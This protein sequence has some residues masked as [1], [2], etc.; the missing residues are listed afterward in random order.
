MVFRFCG[1]AINLTL[2]I[3]TTFSSEGQIIG[4]D[5]PPL[6]TPTSSLDLT[7]LLA[8]LY[9]S[10]GNAIFPSKICSEMPESADLRMCWAEVLPLF[11]F[12]FQSLSR[13]C[14]QIFLARG[15]LVSKALRHH[16]SFVMKYSMTVGTTSLVIKALQEKILVKPL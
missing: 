8:L 6:P 9:E 5:K 1:N 14:S 7:F 3:C 15:K 13:A 12:R 10:R 4:E 2:N 16:L 11:I